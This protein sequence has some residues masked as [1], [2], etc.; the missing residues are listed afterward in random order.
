LTAFGSRDW[1]RVGHHTRDEQL[2]LLIVERSNQLIDV[3]DWVGE[4]RVERRLF[5]QACLAGLKQNRELDRDSLRCNPLTRRG[6]TRN[7]LEE[8]MAFG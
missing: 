4:W 5:C 6:E 7:D 1:F 8:T 3:H 2:P